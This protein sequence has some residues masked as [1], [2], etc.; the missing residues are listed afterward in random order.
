M[1]IVTDKNREDIIRSLNY[2]LDCSS[3][4]LKWYMDTGNEKYLT[5]C[6]MYLRVANI[7]MTEINKGKKY[8]DCCNI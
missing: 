7:Y 1:I 4:R 5:D 3:Q 6:W 2:T 8:E